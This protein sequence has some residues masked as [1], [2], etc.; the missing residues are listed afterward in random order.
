MVYYLFLSNGEQRDF[1]RIL[2]EHL[3]DFKQFLFNVVWFN[4][5]T[6]FDDFK[7]VCLWWVLPRWS[8]CFSKEWL[9]LYEMSFMYLTFRYQYTCISIVRN[10]DR[11]CQVSTDLPGQEW[12]PEQ[13]G[14][15]LSLPGGRVPLA[16]VWRR[17]GVN[18]SSWSALRR[19]VQRVS[20]VSG[21]KAAC[22]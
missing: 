22:S 1:Q 10:Q 7:V 17:W 19:P 21:S 18:Q 20:V 13:Q 6:Q 4:V 15:R 14:A 5:Y 2:R 9:T 8:L 12:G 11:E 3:L 16:F